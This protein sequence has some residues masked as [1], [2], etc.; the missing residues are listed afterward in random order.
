MI[1]DAGVEPLETRSQWG[2]WIIFH[3]S[4]TSPKMSSLIYLAR[5]LLLLNKNLVVVV[6][7]GKVRLASIVVKLSWA[8]TQSPSGLAY[9]GQLGSGKEGRRSLCDWV[10]PHSALTQSPAESPL[11][12]PPNLSLPWALSR[13]RALL[14]SIVGTTTWSQS[15]LNLPRYILQHIL[16]PSASLEKYKRQRRRIPSH[17]QSPES[18]DAACIPLPLSFIK[19]L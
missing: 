8:R 11:P 15:P 3:F 16:T 6:N 9:R 14:S 5:K 13:P 12:S 19:L 18:R 4:K 17:T 10:L 1:L 2:K 7:A